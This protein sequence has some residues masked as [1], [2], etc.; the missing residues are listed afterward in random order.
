MLLLASTTTLAAPRYTIKVGHLAPTNDPRHIALEHFAQVLR[1][2]TN[3]EVQVVIYPNSALGSERELFE[4]VQAGITEMALIA[5]VIG[6]FYPPLGIMDMPYLWKT[7]EDL[8][9]FLTGPIGQNWVQDM[10]RQRGVGVAAFFDRNPRVLVTRD[11]PV[12]SMADLRGM[13]IRVPEIAT[14]IDTWRA[15][16]VQPVAI[17]ASEF[18]MALKLGVIDGMENPVEVHYNWK[19]YEVAKYLSVTEHQRAVLP[20]IY[21]VSALQRLPAA[22]QQ[23]FWDAARE[24]EAMHN[25]MVREEEQRLYEALKEKGMTIV[26]P[27]KTEFIQASRQV[28]EK[29]RDV[30]G[31]GVLDRVLRGD[32]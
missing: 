25:R 8:R 31:A 9:R 32:F 6:N 21:N 22:Y 28:W 1:D 24:A 11:R 12:R 5:A 14:S 23:A 13:K 16:G 30:F 17:P 3:G 20:L 2:K 26:Y 29:Y 19:I 4:Q 10:V 15:F 7:Q 27:D 18:Y